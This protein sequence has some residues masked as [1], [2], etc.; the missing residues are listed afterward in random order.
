MAAMVVLGLTAPLALADDAEKRVFTVDVAEDLNTFVPGPPIIGGVPQ[1]GSFFITEG[2][3]YPGGTIPGDGSTFDPT[4]PNGP[5]PIGRWFCRGTHLVAGDQIPGTT[6][7]W[8][9]TSQ[10]YLLP[11]DQQS[12]DTSGV[13]QT[14]PVVRTVTGGTG[15]FKDVFGV[16][17][18]EF[19]GAF[20]TTGGANLR[21]TF[22][23]R[24]ATHAD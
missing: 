12:L 9:Y 6:A 11:D 24:K 1:R 10:L 19:L 4:D 23:L 13:E 5:K 18:Q 15:K 14:A 21:V 3:I 2:K 8:V 20:N 17:K 16:Q 22:H 7:P